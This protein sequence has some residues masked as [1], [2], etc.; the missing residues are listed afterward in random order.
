VTATRLFVTVAAVCGALVLFNVAS[1]VGLGALR[2]REA[3]QVISE[4]VDLLF[5]SIEE[6]AFRETYDLRTSVEF[7]NAV[8]RE[9]YQQL[10]DRVR[11]RLGPLLA[12]QLRQYQT[13]T[14]RGMTYY[15]LAYTADF[16][17]GKGSIN[18]V[19]RKS[20]EGWVLVSL[21][22]Q[23]PEFLKDLASARCSRCGE[24][25]PATARF[26]PS[27]GYPVGESKEGGQAWVRPRKDRTSAPGEDFGTLGTMSSYGPAAEET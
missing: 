20:A 7:R 8:S 25:H 13:R 18:T 15:G 21:N 5:A 3:T 22:V 27:C 24:P 23:S 6:G 26:C 19:F 17:C 16:Q 14:Q 10:A 9:Q 2:Y 12:K 11:A 4:E 1:C